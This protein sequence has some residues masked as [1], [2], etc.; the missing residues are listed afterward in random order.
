MGWKK[1]QS[2]NPAGRPRGTAKV[3]KLRSLIE[4]DMPE[5][6]AK[7]VELA[8]E[9]DMSAAK[10]LVDRVIPTIRPVEQPRITPPAGD[11]LVERGEAVLNAMQA[12]QLAPGEAQAAIGALMAQGKLVELSEIEKRLAMLEERLDEQ[13]T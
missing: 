3:A 10:L 11:S 8:K 13:Q 4:A 6:I 12:G 7:V 9:G 5:V 2:G 1:G